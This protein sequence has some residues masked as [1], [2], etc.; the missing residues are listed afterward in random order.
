MLTLQAEY[1]ELE[2]GMPEINGNAI[3]ANP[4][5]CVI[6]SENEF[7]TSFNIQ[8]C[9]AGRTGVSGIIGFKMVF[10]AKD[11]VQLKINDC[12]AISVENRRRKWVLV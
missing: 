10:K 3:T 8:S 7:L 5:N 12:R 1:N 4:F 6:N 9:S 11:L 2:I